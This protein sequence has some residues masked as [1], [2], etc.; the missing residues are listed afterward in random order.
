M[1]M[2]GDGSL[3]TLFVV[4]QPCQMSAEGGGSANGAGGPS[5]GGALDHVMQRN[6]MLLS[7]VPSIIT[8]FDLHVSH[9]LLT[10]CTT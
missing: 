2:F 6:Y 5:S 4:P 7:T 1:A 10:T 3:S 8:L 9:K